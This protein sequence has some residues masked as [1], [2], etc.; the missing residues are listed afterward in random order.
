MTGFFNRWKR[1]KQKAPANQKP[2]AEFSV[3]IY[4]D[5][6]ECNIYGDEK[7]IGGALTSLMLDNQYSHHIIKNSIIAVERVLEKEHALSELMIIN[8]N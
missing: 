2:I 1:K 5:R 7:M 6:V 8:L 4:P 3:N